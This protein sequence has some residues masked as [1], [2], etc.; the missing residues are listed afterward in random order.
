MRFLVS[1]PIQLTVEYGSNRTHNFQGEYLQ[2]RD[3][4][5]SF[6]LSPLADRDRAANR[7]YV[8]DAVQ[9][10]TNTNRLGEFIVFDSRKVDEAL[11]WVAAA[12]AKQK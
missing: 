10:I 11:A 4:M 2:E 9:W 12:P 1:V 5:R 8:Q 6:L 3:L 7:F